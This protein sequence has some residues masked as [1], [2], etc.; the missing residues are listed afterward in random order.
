[1]SRVM[2]VDLSKQSGFLC[3]GS[4]GQYKPTHTRHILYDSSAGAV[5]RAIPPVHCLHF[6][7]CL[8][9]SCLT[10]SLC[11]FP[12]FFLFP[13]IVFEFQQCPLS[14]NF[15]RRSAH[16]VHT[17]LHPALVSLG[18]GVGGKNGFCC[19]HASLPSPWVKLDE[20]CFA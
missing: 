20:M 8:C 3:H 17:R 9:L 13:H 2:S 10:I 14:L 12:L 7:L 6:F 11:S 4:E 15:I 1:M 5:P 19:F 18:S 16:V